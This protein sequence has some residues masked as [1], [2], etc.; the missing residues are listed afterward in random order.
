M[1]AA[2]AERRAERRQGGARPEAPEAPQAPEAPEAPQAPR[3]SSGLSKQTSRLRLD[4]VTSS[5]RD[6]SSPRACVL[7]VRTEK[8][9]DR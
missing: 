9:S 8:V 4:E 7:I 2:R 5:A 1:K 6:A 3:G